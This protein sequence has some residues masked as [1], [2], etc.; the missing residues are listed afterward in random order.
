M[1]VAEA[2]GDGSAPGKI[3]L[4]KRANDLALETLPMIDDVIRNA[5]VLGHEAGGVDRVERGAAALHG[6][7]QAC[8]TG[9]A[10]LVPDLH[11][12]ADDGVSLGAKHGRDGG[13]IHTARHGYGNGL[14]RWH[15][16]VI[17]SS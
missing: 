17:C 12:Q 5:D 6:P 10:P 3:F 7:G 9:E 13:G 1:I 14:W 11:G 16:E 8:V 2:A 15:G 4:D